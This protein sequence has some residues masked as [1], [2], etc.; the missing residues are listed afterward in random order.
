MP[1]LY[2]ELTF[3]AKVLELY[4]TNCMYTTIQLRNI[5][6]FKKLSPDITITADVEEKIKKICFFGIEFSNGF[7]IQR[8]LFFKK[9]KENGI[10]LSEKISLGPALILND[11]EAQSIG[12]LG[13]I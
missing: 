2:A 6:F 1:P 9:L 11:D 13:F 8:G 4:K 10:K 7:K 5:A 3:F 12:P